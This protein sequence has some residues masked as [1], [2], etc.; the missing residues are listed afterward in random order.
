MWAFP[1]TF[2]LALSSALCASLSHTYWLA[3]MHMRRG[4]TTTEIPLCKEA[5]TPCRNYYQI[6]SSNFFQLLIPGRSGNGVETNSFGNVSSPGAPVV[7][8]FFILGREILWEIWREFCG[9]FFRHANE[10]SKISGAKDQ[11]EVFLHKVCLRPPRVMDVCVFGSRTSAPKTLF[12][13]APSNGVKAFGS[14]L[15]GSHRSTHIASDLASQPLASQAKLHR[16]SE[17]QA[18]RIA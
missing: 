1:C 4:R 12:S 10:G 3:C 14:G 16:D 5:S 17:S 2:S 7:G 8:K 18:F 11:P 15:S 9:I 6:N 13:C